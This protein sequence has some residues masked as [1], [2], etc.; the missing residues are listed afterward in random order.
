[1]PINMVW[2]GRNYTRLGLFSTAG[3]H[4]SC[5]SPIA[6]S[7]PTE[8]PAATAGFP[9]NLKESMMTPKFLR[10]EAARFRGMAETADREASKARLL[11][12]A[13]D[14]EA[15]AEAAEESTKPDVGDQIKVGERI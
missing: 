3:V 6:S 5:I 15:R 7:V 8:P 4:T 13:A 2:A 14:Y 11:T 10:Q 1:M 9:T 12:M